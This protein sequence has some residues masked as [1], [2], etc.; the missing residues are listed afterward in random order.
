[1]K[2]KIEELL[3][4]SRKLEQLIDS[5]ND[6][7]GYLYCDDLSMMEINYLDPDE[8]MQQKELSRIMEQLNIIKNDLRYLRS[9]IKRQ[10]KL[11]LNKNGRYELEGHE[12]HCGDGLEVRIYDECFERWKWVCTRLEHNGNEFYLVDYSDAEI[13]GLNARL[14]Y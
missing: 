9:P 11:F 5:L 14:R 8:I 7:S 2:T 6:L 3:N 10:G 1:M 4:K 13:Q 12:F